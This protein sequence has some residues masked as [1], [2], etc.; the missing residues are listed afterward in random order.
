MGAAGIMMLT[1]GSPAAKVISIKLSPIANPMVQIPRR[2]N[3]TA[4]TRLYATA[5]S[6][7]KKSV[8]C[9]TEE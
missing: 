9:Y 1:I 4:T 2:G 5:R 7:K 6:E 8:T 3:S